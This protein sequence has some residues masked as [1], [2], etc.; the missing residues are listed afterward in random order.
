MKDVKYTLRVASGEIRKGTL[1]GQGKAKLE[2]LVPGPF[3]IRFEK[4]STYKRL[5]RK[6]R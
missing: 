5:S 3:A 2:N 6:S 4:R 1:D